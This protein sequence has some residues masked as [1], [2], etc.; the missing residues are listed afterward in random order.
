[1]YAKPHEVM[2]LRGGGTQRKKS[3]RTGQSDTLIISSDPEDPAIERQV[4]LVSQCSSIKATCRLWEGRG[5][6]ALDVTF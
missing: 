3:V 6:L 2:Q 1:M 4:R 5:Y